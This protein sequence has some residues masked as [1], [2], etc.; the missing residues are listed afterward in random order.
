MDFRPATVARVL[1]YEL[2]PCHGQWS[3]ASAERFVQGSY[4]A[5]L[6]AVL[7]TQQCANQLCWTWPR[8]A[9]SEEQQ[10]LSTS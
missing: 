7:Q 1:L 9:G 10:H 2:R 5:G 3:Q 6:A 4:C 8:G